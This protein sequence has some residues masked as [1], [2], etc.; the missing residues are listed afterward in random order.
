MVIMGKTVV[1]YHVSKDLNDLEGAKLMYLTDAIRV[2][3]LLNNG[4]SNPK[5]PISIVVADEVHEGT[6][7]TQMIIGFTR[8][9]DGRWSLRWY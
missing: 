1:G 8:D 4:G 2:Y 5:H 3:A 7:Y 9:A 6:M